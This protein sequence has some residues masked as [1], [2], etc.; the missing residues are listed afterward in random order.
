MSGTNDNNSNNNV[1]SSAA[2]SGSGGAGSSSSGNWRAQLKAHVDVL[3]AFVELSSPIRNGT[4][5]PTPRE[6]KI[7]D[8]MT[9]G[10]S[11]PFESLLPIHK[12]RFAAEILCQECKTRLILGYDGAKFQNITDRFSQQQENIRSFSQVLAECISKFDQQNSR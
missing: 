3:D 4:R 11:D 2:S 7:Q 1:A 12:A 5:T 10:A 8:A 6:Q 9:Q